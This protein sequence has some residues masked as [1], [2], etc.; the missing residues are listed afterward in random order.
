MLPLEKLSEIGLLLIAFHIITFSTLLWSYRLYCWIEAKHEC[1]FQLKTSLDRECWVVKHEYA[2]SR[3]EFIKQGNTQSTTEKKP[4]MESNR[5]TPHKK[6]I[7]HKACPKI[8]VQSHFTACIWC[9]FWHGLWVVQIYICDSTD[10]NQFRCI[11]RVPIWTFS[12]ISDLYC[13]AYWCIFPK[14]VLCVPHQG[15]AQGQHM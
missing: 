14:A 7:C 1:T 8:I 10:I 4:M 6:H 3:V 9:I 15:D 11:L 5:Y 12:P 2:V 13:Y